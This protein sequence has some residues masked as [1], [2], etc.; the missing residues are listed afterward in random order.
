MI[1]S[2]IITAAA[3]IFQETLVDIGNRICPKPI[4]SHPVPQSACNK[5]PTSFILDNVKSTIGSQTGY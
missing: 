4:L 3:K 1:S 2:R 5:K